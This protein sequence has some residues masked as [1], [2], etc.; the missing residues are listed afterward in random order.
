MVAMEVCRGRSH[1]GLYEKFRER[2]SVMIYIQATSQIWQR[3]THLAWALDRQG[4]V[5]PAS[6]VLI[7][8]CAL[9]A[10]AAVLSRDA[11]FRKIPGLDVRDHLG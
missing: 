1:Q 5:L 8:A 10:G 9:Q 4:A 7:A 3:A 2:F 6:D 11:H